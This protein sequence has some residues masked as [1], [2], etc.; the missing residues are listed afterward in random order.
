MKKGYVYIMRDVKGRLYIGSTDDLA[1]RM[2]QHRSKHTQT[3]S[4]MEKPVVV[5]S[6]KYGSL[7]IARKIERKLK[8]LKRKD[9]VERVI[10]DGFIKMAL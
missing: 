7:E 4:R 8:R 1:R 5:L 3:T 2:R 9:Y 10:R 6:Q